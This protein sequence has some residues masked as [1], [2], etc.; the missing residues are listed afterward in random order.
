[1]QEVGGSIPPSST[2]IKGPT[3]A[4]SPSSRG[5]GHR[6]FTAVTGVRIPLGTPCHSDVALLY[7]HTMH[8][9]RTRIAHL[10]D[11]MGRSAPA[12]SRIYMCSP[13]SYLYKKCR[14]PRTSVIDLTVLG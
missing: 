14:S 7:R 11:D 8:G 6:P 9:A 10:C 5:P 12:A 1:M 3:A 4:G 2:T 13:G